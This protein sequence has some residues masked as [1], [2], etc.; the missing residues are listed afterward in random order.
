MGSF[1]VTGLKGLLAV[2]SVAGTWPEKA[3]PVPLPKA[4]VVVEPKPAEL[5]KAPVPVFVVADVPNPVAGLFAPKR[6]L[7][8]VVLLPKP[9]VLPVV[10]DPKPPEPNPVEVAV[11]VALFPKR[12]PPVVVVPKP[13]GLLPPKREVV[14]GWLLPKPIIK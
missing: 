12:P 4:L 14:W 9:P 3:L 10:V 5:P 1:S 8:V 13:L 7:P 6:V 11:L 2:P